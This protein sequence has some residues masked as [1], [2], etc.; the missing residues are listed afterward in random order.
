MCTPSCIGGIKWNVG[1]GASQ[2]CSLLLLHG[3]VTKKKRCVLWRH[4]LTI[5]VAYQTVAEAADK[6]TVL[7]VSL[8]PFGGAESAVH[9]AMGIQRA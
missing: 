2:T 5:L 7:I 4:T 3:H 6:A 8:Q 9:E 1:V